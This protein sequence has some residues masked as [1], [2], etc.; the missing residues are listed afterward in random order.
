MNSNR[1]EARAINY[2]EDLLLECVHIDFNIS[3]NDKG[4]SWDGFIFLF[5]DEDHKKENLV[6]N[7][8]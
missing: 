7:S 2:L 6:C 1:I 4:L 3:K 8:S 5:S